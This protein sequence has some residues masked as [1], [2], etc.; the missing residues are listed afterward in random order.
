MIPFEIDPPDKPC[1]Y[2]RSRLTHAQLYAIAIEAYAKT[3]EEDGG[4]PEEDTKDAM[5]WAMRQALKASSPSTETRESRLR[6]FCEFIKTWNADESMSD[7]LY[8]FTMAEAW[9]ER[10][11]NLDC[12][13]HGITQPN[14]ECIYCHG[15]GAMDSGGETPWG[16]SIDVRCVCTYPEP[17]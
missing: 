7:E 5:V 12:P 15:S 14:P 13:L 8:A 16:A 2:C 1:P 10:N 9:L 3:C 4:D 11:K 6:D 17:V